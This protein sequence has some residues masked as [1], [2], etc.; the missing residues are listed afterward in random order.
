MVK[1]VIPVVVFLI[2][3]V[4]LG[5]LAYFGYQ[6]GNGPVVKYVLAIILPVV[7]II[8]WGYFAAPKSDHRLAM[9]YVAMFR[10]G[11][12]LAASY[13]LYKCGE[14]RIALILALVSTA[15]QLACLYLE[16]EE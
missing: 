10:L 3:L 5:S 9:P 15:T 13:A 2:E 14:T 11:M 16:I 8:L 12:F 6:K 4:M 7:S 1:I